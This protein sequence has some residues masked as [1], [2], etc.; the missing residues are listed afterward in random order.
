[1]ILGYDLL[2]KQGLVLQNW[3]EISGTHAPLTLVWVQT[4]V[5]QSYW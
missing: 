5:I 2:Q 1:M 4:E 3:N